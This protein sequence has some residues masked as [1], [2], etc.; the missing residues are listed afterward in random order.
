MEPLPRAAIFDIDGTLA[1]MGARSPY[2]WEK[3]GMDTLNTRVADLARMM[4]VGGHKILVFSGRDSVCRK[5]TEDW[6][7]LNQIGYNRLYMRPQGDF[8]KD[9]EVKREFY[10]A[11]KDEYDIRYAV[12][13]RLQVCRLWHELGLC[14]LRVGDPE[15][16]F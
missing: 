1:T 9:V 12:D 15:A 6:L 5:E 16:D 3:V 13:D 8:R 14:L 10:E 2:D 7:T 11:C 4:R